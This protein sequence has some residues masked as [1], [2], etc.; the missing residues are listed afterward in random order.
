MSGPGDETKQ[1]D[2]AGKAAAGPVNGLEGGQRSPGSKPA[3]KPTINPQGL[4]Y[5]AE[6]GLML[7]FAAISL[8]P[9]ESSHVPVRPSDLRA[10]SACAQARLAQRPVATVDGTVGTTTVGDLLEAEDA[11]GVM[12]A[13]AAAMAAKVAAGASQ[14]AAEPGFGLSTSNVEDVDARL[15]SVV[16]AAAS[17]DDVATPPEAMKVATVIVPAVVPVVAPV[18][19]VALQTSLQ[20]G[21]DGNGQTAQERPVEPTAIKNVLETEVVR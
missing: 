1:E 18:A 13:T 5:V 6:F 2:E 21:L 14:A 4:I 12:A 19:L 10:A 16:A 20:D 17:L 7:A 8:W 11:C 3:E 9:L 15:A